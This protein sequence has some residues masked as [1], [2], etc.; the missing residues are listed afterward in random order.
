MKAIDFI[1]RPPSDKLS[2]FTEQRNKTT[3]GGV[4]FLI[5]IIAILLITFI[6]LFDHFNN[7]PYTIESNTIIDSGAA[8]H[9]FND[10]AFDQATNFSFHIYTDYR[11]TREVSDRF[12]VVDYTISED[13][14]YKNIRHIG[15]TKKPSEV[16]LAVYYECHNETVCKYFEDGRTDQD[17]TKKNY[18]FQK[19]S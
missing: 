17:Y 13:Y 2:I 11:K 7:L 19:L 1:T 16:K 14:T 9:E 10:D 5:E 3:L 15:I 6:Y 18:I 12:K 8:V 4:I